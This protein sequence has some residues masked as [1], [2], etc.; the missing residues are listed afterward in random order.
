MPAVFPDGAASWLRQV[1]ALPSPTT[2]EFHAQSDVI[3]VEPLA[4]EL[5]GLELLGEQVRV[6]M[7]GLD[8][9]VVL[10]KHDEGLQ[11]SLSIFIPSSNLVA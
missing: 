11:I 9:L 2:C 5:K 8:D 7:K 3:V 10:I 4:G 1:T 6:V